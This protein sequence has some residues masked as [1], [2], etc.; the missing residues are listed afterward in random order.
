MTQITYFFII[1]CLFLNTT[2]SAS[3]TSISLAPKACVT[4]ANKEIICLSKNARSFTPAERCRLIEDRLKNLSRDLSFNP[5]HLYIIKEKDTTNIVTENLVIISLSDEDALDFAVARDELAVRLQVKIQESIEEE[6]RTKHPKVLLSALVFSFI[7][8]ICYGVLMFTL[9]LGYKKINNRISDKTLSF[10]RP[11]AFWNY[12]ILSRQSLVRFLIW[13]IRN[14]KFITNLLLF[15]IYIS[16]VFSFFPQT[17]TLT[18]KLIDYAVTPIHEILS[19]VIGFIPN[20]FFILAIAF[21]TKYILQ[22]VEFIFEEIDNGNLII[23]GFYREWAQ[24]TYKLVRFIIC[25]FAFVMAFPYI[26]GS[27]SPAF[28]GVTV[29]LGLLLSIGSSSAVSNIVSGIVITYMRPFKVGDSVKIADTIGD[30]IERNLFVTRIRTMKEVEITIPNSMAL[31]SHIVNF[32]VN[33]N[34]TGVVLN[35]AISIT[36]DIPW[37][38][39]HELLKKAALSTAYLEHE[40]E[41]FILQL[42]LKDSCVSYD[43]NAYTRKPCQMPFIYS[44]LHQHIQDCFHEAGIAIKLPYFLQ[45][46]D[47]SGLEVPHRKDINNKLGKFLDI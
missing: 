18:A 42:G 19:L 38:K 14:V 45:M 23:E 3:A 36:Y 43:L 26:P 34:T 29:F 8:S 13:L 44:E 5:Q 22:L 6:R 32:S 33:A 46:Q 7:A 39:V 16:V 40:P 12:E 27:S 1:L 21:I 24:P 37:R 10:I 30:V 25:A 31:A 2:A 4:F 35:T 11:I 17:A 9:S 28:K 20:V 47:A 15:Y 41:P